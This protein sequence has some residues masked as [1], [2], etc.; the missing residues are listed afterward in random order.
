LSIAFSLFGNFTRNVSPSLRTSTSF[1]NVIY[2]YVFFDLFDFF[3]RDHS[4][5]KFKSKFLIVQKVNKLSIKNFL[6]SHMTEKDITLI[7]FAGCVVNVRLEWSV[8]VHPSVWPI[9]LF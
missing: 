2:R 1:S 8:A 4:L 3:V 9:R 6:H 7:G 5:I